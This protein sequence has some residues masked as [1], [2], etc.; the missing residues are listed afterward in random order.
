MSEPA[1]HLHDPYATHQPVL[2]VALLRT[3]GP[4]IEFGCGY[5]STPLL[6][7]VCKR[8]GRKLTT[9]ENNRDWLDRFSEYATDWHQFVHAT[10][11]Q[12][13]LADIVGQ[14]YGLAFVDQAPFEA[15]HA[16][17]LTVKDTARFVVL[18]DCDYFPEHGLFGKPLAWINGTRDRGHRIYDDVFKHWQEF[19]PL[20]P[21]PYPPSGPPTLLASNFE[22]CDWEIDFEKFRHEDDFI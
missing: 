5:G 22:P 9:L 6:H 10:D 14:P 7:R 12:T 2:Y 8:H 15:R 11:W 4:V 13:V 20:E 17:I 16:T 21:W 3:E 18:H 1:R 19:F